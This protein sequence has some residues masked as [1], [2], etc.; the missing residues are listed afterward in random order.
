MCFEK[1]MTKC[2]AACEVWF[3]RLY[4]MNANWQRRSAMPYVIRWVAVLSCSQR[5][6]INRSL[7]MDW[8]AGEFQSPACKNWNKKKYRVVESHSSISSRPNSVFASLPR[9]SINQLLFIQAKKPFVSN[10]WQRF[11]NKQ[12]VGFSR[13]PCRLILQPT[14]HGGVESVL[15]NVESCKREMSDF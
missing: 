5:G 14:H 4:M 3:S 12:G 10:T 6:S 11:L 7:I 13:Q 9:R 15:A 2:V 8:A 1:K